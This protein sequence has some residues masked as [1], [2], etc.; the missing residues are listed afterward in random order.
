M[1][2]KDIENLIANYPYE[3][4]PYQNLRLIGQ[5]VRLETYF[6]DI[7]FENE[8]KE[9]IIIE[10][11]RGIMHRD[12]IPQIMDYYGILKIKKPKSI[13]HLII[14]AN[15]IPKERIVFL[16]ERLGIQFIEIPISKLLNA[17]R[18]HS[19]VFLDSDT[20]R[21]QQKYTKEA[22]RLDESVFK[23]SSNVWIFQADP[24]RFDILNALEELNE[25]VWG[26]KRFKYEIK[27]G[28]IGIVWM[29][30]KDAGIYAVSEIVSNHDFLTEAKEVAKFW[31]SHTDKD[32][33]RLCVRLEYKVKLQNNPIFREEL[34][35]IP[36]LK[37]MSILKQAR[38]T[39]FRVTEN[40]WRAVSVLIKKRI[41]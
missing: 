41:Q 7:M 13:I 14:I 17:A 6:S 39:N 32:Q 40:E 9:S 16:S 37:N 38:G 11:K 10:V 2:E 31:R 23:R 19:Y 8:M 29:S 20:A 4:L 21:M 24:K 33:I 36:E 28:D 27:A 30:G 26:V 12:A 15:V 25:D 34:K 35:S 22:Q 18:R 3:F 5:Q 1:L